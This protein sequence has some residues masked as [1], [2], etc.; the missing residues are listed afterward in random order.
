MKDTKR[1][2]H[3]FLLLGLLFLSSCSI[4]HIIPQDQLLLVRN[5]ITTNDSLSHVPLNNLDVYIRQ[6]P[7]RKT[8]S[9][10]PFNLWIYAIT[11]PPKTHGIK[12]WLGL[13][14]LGDIIGEAPVLIDETQAKKSAEEM[15][16]TLFNNGY[17]NSVVNYQ[18]DTLAPKRGKVTY[19]ID[20]KKPYIIDTLY[21]NIENDSIRALIL[22]TR[23]KTLIKKGLNYN[24]DLFEQERK[25]IEFLL[26]DNGYYYFSKDLIVLDVDSN[27]NRVSITLN[28][29]HSKLPKEYYPYFYKAM[30]RYT[31]AK[32]YLHTNY[33]R[34]KILENKVKYRSTLDTIPFTNDIYIVNRGLSPVNP[35]I[36]LKRNDIIPNTYYSISNVN[37]LIDYLWKLDIYKLVNIRFTEDSLS[38]SNNRLICE[39]ELS[40]FSKYTTTTEVEGT[41]SSGNLGMAGSVLFKDRSLFNRAEIFNMRVKGAIQHQLLS[42]SGN[43]E[44]VIKY[45]AFNTI[46]FTVDSR[47]TFP[48]FVFPIR[49]SR[50]ERNKN[51]HTSI[52]LDFN[53]QNRP[54]YE[55]N[56][57]N[58]AF[59][60]YWQHKK[61]YLHQLNLLEVNSVKVYSLA[62]NFYHTIK[63][64]FLEQSYSDHFIY[65]TSYM[66][67]INNQILHPNTAHLFF[68]SHIESS[69]NLL[70]AF[71]NLNKTIPNNDGSYHIFGL[72]YSQ[73][74][75]GEIDIRYYVPLLHHQKIVYRNYIGIGYPYKNMGVLP[76]E[77]R[78][79]SGG[80]NGIRAWA[81]RTLGPGTYLDT[82][83]TYPNQSGDLKLETNLEYRFPI[84][85]FIESA[86]FID[87]GNIWSLSEADERPGT[88]FHFPDFIN[89]LAIG[90]GT[91]LRFNFSFFLIRIDMGIKAHNPVM[92]TGQRWTILHGIKNNDVN[93]NFGI[94]YPF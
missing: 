46:N 66:F 10:I 85:S 69:G 21:Y 74:L 52:T 65:A 80:A 40:P 81:I 42:T 32:I 63:G 33:N 57:V 1:I 36:L 84:W 94:G 44:K 82:I 13:Y 7:N 20:S 35:K 37:R 76:F 47:L 6:H 70:T 22:E 24:I 78:F 92:P 55:N 88:R 27:K 77:K 71:N 87:M 38:V 61:I 8:V 53:Y 50:F 64:T 54:E 45:A 29:H 68:R 39:I 15:Q 2:R 62:D 83:S 59:G 16:K 73:Y 30:K 58:A 91:G 93:F 17:F 79:Y 23:Q 18:I 5:K 34:K 4:N 60:Y 26:K 56:I 89:E 28:I 75:L 12:Y 31:I 9:V 41:N 43:D 86:L 11:H 19:L 90:I 48:K 51:P 25:R 67:Q 14:K 72:P 3:Y 49:L